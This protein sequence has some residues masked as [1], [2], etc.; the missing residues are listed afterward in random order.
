MALGMLRQQARALLE[1]GVAAADP[2]QAIRRELS[3]RPVTVPAGGRLFV[4]ALGVS[5][6]AMVEEALHHLPDAPQ[7]MAI[8]VTSRDN[9]RD[10]QGCRVFGTGLDTPDGDGLIAASVIGQMLSS[11]GSRDRVLCLIS[12]GG[13]ALVPYPKSRI[14]LND[15]IF[16]T[17]LMRE[18]GCEPRDISLVTQH[19][20]LIEGGGL[21]ALAAPAE[22]RSLIV[23]DLVDNDMRAIAGGP[24]AAPLGTVKDAIAL[25]QDLEIWSAL[26]DGIRTSLKA[27][28]DAAE[29]L[30]KIAADN[31]V[32]CSNDTCLDAIAKT[33]GRDRSKII[34]NKL[35]GSVDVAAQDIAAQLRREEMNT[36]G[37]AIWGGEVG[38]AGFGSGRSGRNQEL[39]LRMA[40]ESEIVSGPWVFVS[41]ATCGRDGST[42]AAGGIVDS[43][44][45][46]RIAGAVG[47]VDGFLERQDSYTALKASQDLLFVGPTGADVAD[48]QLF[49]KI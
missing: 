14:S 4:I 10:V 17:R 20:S 38:A 9:V 19:L 16:V 36:C 29:A 49:L 18:K 40:L 1:T 39:A 11:T 13:S 8:A 34:A 2:A 47:S 24:T 44:T 12:G 15:Q 3:A 46:G 43:E 23:S 7:I 42:D 5:A 41:A 33:A 31:K 26:P 45:R 48:V 37:V 27:D 30:P 28:S 22:V 21:T 35:R 6:V 32:V 25:L